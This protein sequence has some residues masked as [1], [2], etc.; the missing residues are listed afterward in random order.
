MHRIGLIVNSRPNLDQQ[1]VSNAVARTSACVSVCAHAK[2]ARGVRG[3]ESENPHV[4][5]SYCVIQGIPC[6]IYCEYTVLF[7]SAE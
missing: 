5:L 1:P 4:C 6:Y 3:I 2:R 7:C